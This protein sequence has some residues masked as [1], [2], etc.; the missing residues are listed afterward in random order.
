MREIRQWF[1]QLFDGALWRKI[2]GVLLIAVAFYFVSALIFMVL[3]NGM[4]ISG[5][6]EVE[7][8]T[9]WWKIY[10]LFVDAG[11]QISIAKGP[12]LVGL[13]V[14]TLGSIFLSGLLISTITNAFERQSDKWRNGFSYYKLKDHI[15][16][17][18]SDQMVQGLVNQ[19]CATSDSDIVV[20][21]STDVE[22]MR[23]SLRVV[24][25]DKK[26]HERIIVNYGQRDSE[27]YLNLI[28]IVQAKEVYILGDTS[29]FDDIES[30]HD[31]MNVQCLTLIAKLCKKA[32]RKQQLPCNVLFDYKTTYHLFQYADLSSEITDYIDF[33]PFNFCDFWARKVLVAGCS[34]EII[35]SGVVN[36]IRYSSLDYV[37]ITQ[38]DSDRFVHFIIIGMS[39]MGQAMALQAAHIAHFPNYKRKKT[40]ITFID[41][42]GRVEM[43][44]FK[45]KCG[46]LFKVSRSTF[47][48]ADAWLEAEE[49]WSQ[50]D[51]AVDPERYITNYG[52][53]DEYRHLVSETDSDKEFIDVEWEFI[54]GDDHNPIVQRLLKE[55]VEDDNAIVTVAVCL[56]IGHIS[57]RSAMHLPK[58]YYEK[59]IPILVQQRKSS[60]MVAMLNGVGLDT[61]DRDKLLYKNITPFGMVGD[62][63]DL[64]LASSIE[65]CKRIAATYD[66]Y[67]T[68]GNIPSCINSADADKLWHSTRMTKKWSN[69]FA[70]A[71]IPT[72]LRCIGINWD[73]NTPC[74]LKEMTEDQVAL[75][76]EIE[77]NRWNIEE[78]LLGYRP[79]KCAEDQEIDADRSR[80]K[81]WK[82][83]F[84][85]YDIR[86]FDGLKED[87]TGRKASVYD[88]VIVR[89]LPLIL[90]NL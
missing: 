46:E 52:I 68:Y 73:I 50:G 89:S 67:F 44:E 78:L 51:P 59:N 63:Y 55:Y 3:A 70:A 15:V 23:N 61:A 86:P 22:T 5:E 18:G 77:H 11:N 79:V 19:L 53:A 35:E 17:I 36:E 66:H 28:N 26:N 49:R 24:L 39:K 20:M 31:S 82:E 2:A 16:I 56:N 14:G 57:L 75:L 83:R 8:M 33:H 47:I 41:R 25:P 90:K 13:I 81:Y 54:K 32:N 37:P 76:A 21:T 34:R 87:N 69:I 48:D 71:S 58:A 62:C 85:H 4:E 43:N 27:N 42:D 10:Y 29:E 74:P 88:K 45:Q 7:N 60:T 6:S 9:V 72:K 12:R 65:I 80:K 1:R 30:F 64:H 40:K 38:R 84:I